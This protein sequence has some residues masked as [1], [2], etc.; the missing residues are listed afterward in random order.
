MG[1]N[2]AVLEIRRVGLSV[3]DAGLP[4]GCRRPGCRGSLGYA[5]ANLFRRSGSGDLIEA[6]ATIHLRCGCGYV[7]TLALTGAVADS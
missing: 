4:V 6:P 5:T 3:N 1:S 2:V 7:S